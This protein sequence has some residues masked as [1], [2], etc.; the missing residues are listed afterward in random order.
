M[1]N[2]PEWLEDGLRKLDVAAQKFERA[3]TYSRKQAGLD[4]WGD[5]EDARNLALGELL[6]RANLLADVYRQMAAEE[7]RA[8]NAN[9]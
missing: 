2:I 4:E 8:A 6:G 3:N 9:P 5:A 7:R 1:R